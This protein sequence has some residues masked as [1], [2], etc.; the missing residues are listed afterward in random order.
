MD[1]RG[2]GGQKASLRVA[3]VGTPR[4]AADYTNFAPRLGSVVVIH[5]EPGHELALRVGI[6]LWNRAVVSECI[7]CWLRSW[8]RICATVYS[9][10]HAYEFFEE[11]P[12][13][14]EPNQQLH[15]FGWATLRIGIHRRRNYA[16]P[17]AIQW[18]VALQQAFGK[19]QTVTLSY[20]N[21][22][23]LGHWAD[24][25]PGTSNPLFSSFYAF[26]NGPGSNYNSLQLQ[27][28]R[29]PFH[30]LQVLAG[31]TWSHSMDSSSTGYS[32]SSALPL[33]RGNSDNDV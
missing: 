25:S 5:D 18:S 28:K 27:Y 6:V 21:A 10:L 20:V 8:S 4:C 17:K 19:A 30:G 16:P 31:F 22:P 1:P 2:G 33:Q 26:E 12:N 3:P 29:Q 9:H 23:Q 14:D 15:T 11:L 32:N 24:Y 7:R 13:S